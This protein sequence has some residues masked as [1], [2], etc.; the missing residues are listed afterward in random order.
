[1]KNPQLA[2]AL[3][4]LSPESWAAIL[5]GP[6]ALTRC[7]GFKL[8]EGLCEMYGTGDITPDYFA[9]LRAPGP[10]DP[11]LHGFL[12]RHVKDELLIGGCGFK[13]APTADGVVEIA[14]GIV[15]AYEGQGHAT[16]AARL[17][18]AYA[19][20]Q[21]RV[22]RIIAHTKPERNASG[23]VLSKNGFVKVADVVDPDDGPVW[24]WEWRS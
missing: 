6:K 13:G 3:V 18:V 24:Q 1:M 20:S 10:A 22:S 9:K 11:W 23:K 15:P 14:Y 21:S 2:L 16:E 5:A 8:A 7:L 4:P 17:L 12:L 19:R